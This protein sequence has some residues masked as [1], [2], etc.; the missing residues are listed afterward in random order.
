MSAN[1]AHPDWNCFARTN[2]AQRWRKQSATMGRQMTEAIVEEVRVDPGMKVLDVACGTGEPAISLAGLVGESGHV[3]GIDISGEPLKLA[4]QRAQ[5][6]GLS[7]IEFRQG[8][9]HEL[10]FPDHSFDRIS[11]RLGVMFFG[12]LPR[13]FREMHRVLRPAGRIALLVWGPMQQPYFESTALTIVNMIPGA[14]IPEAATA[15]FRF[16]DAGVLKG[17]LEGAGFREVEEKLRTVDWTWPGTP[18][19]VWEY[20]QQATVPFRPLL[21]GIPEEQRERV[22]QAVLEQIRKYY[23]GTKINFTATARIAT[24]IA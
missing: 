15:M 24:G 11:S 21:Q 4:V 6:R 19:E 12:D 16:G 22:N 18:E 10:P 7:N 5:Q 8:D 2:A 9:A 1:P 23:D 17:G 14:K 13:A 3:V 20:F